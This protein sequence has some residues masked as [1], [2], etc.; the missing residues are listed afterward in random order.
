MPQYRRIC[1]NN[2]SILKVTLLENG[3]KTK[4]CVPGMRKHKCANSL[5]FF[6]NRSWREISLKNMLGQ[7]SANFSP[8]GAN[9]VK[10][11]LLLLFTTYCHEL[12]ITKGPIFSLFFLHCKEIYLMTLMHCKAL[13]DKIFDS[14]PLF[15]KTFRHIELAISV[16]SHIT[17]NSAKTF[18]TVHLFSR[19]VYNN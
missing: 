19:F 15:D 17:A 7:D 6:C 10:G 1:P 5:Q 3:K 18:L 12:S 9:Y 16:I 13:C 2:R 14:F 8:S 4:V 11:F